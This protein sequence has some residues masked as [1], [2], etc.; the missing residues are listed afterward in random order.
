MADMTPQPS[1]YPFAGHSHGM[2][3]TW[4]PCLQCNIAVSLIYAPLQELEELHGRYRGQPEHQIRHGLGCP[5][6]PHKPS[7]II[8]LQIRVDPLDCTAIP[9]TQ[10]LRGIHLFLLSSPGV[11]IDDWNMPHLSTV[12]SDLRYIVCRAHQVVKTGAPFRGHLRQGDGCLKSG[13][14]CHAPWEGPSVEILG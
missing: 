10:R 4:Q 8:V 9:E 11:G 3:T 14:S 6:H 1:K 7:T 13:S 12:A 5:A 2:R